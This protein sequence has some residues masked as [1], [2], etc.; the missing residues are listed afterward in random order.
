LGLPEEN[1]E[2]GAEMAGRRLRWR[3]VEE[4]GA[5]ERKVAAGDI[6]VAVFFAPAAYLILFRDWEIGS[7]LR[8][9]AHQG[10]DPNGRPIWIASY[11]I[12]PARSRMCKRRTIVKP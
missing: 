5:A 4:A 10:P 6:M 7:L 11:A 3:R 2:M 1:G 8:A 12:G 9:P